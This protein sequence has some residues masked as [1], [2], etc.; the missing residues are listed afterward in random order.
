M[1]GKDIVSEIV[2]RRIE[3]IEKKGY[4]FGHNVPE[5]RMRTVNPFMEGKGVILEVK[6]ASPSKGDIAPSLDAAAAALRYA[7]CGAGVAQGFDGRLQCAS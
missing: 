2:R 5:K 4:S 7:S 6:R 1:G 3:D